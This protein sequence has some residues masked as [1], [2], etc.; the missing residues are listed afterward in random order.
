MLTA[1]ERD[2]IRLSVEE[3][4]TANPINELVDDEWHVL[5]HFGGRWMW[6]LVNRS[7]DKFLVAI[8]PCMFVSRQAAKAVAEPAKG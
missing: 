7:G 3:W 2:A 6:R 1:E 4:L 5:A 8:S